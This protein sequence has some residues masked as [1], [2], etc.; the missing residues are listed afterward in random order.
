M[1]LFLLLLLFFS[2]LFLKMWKTGMQITFLQ[3]PTMKLHV[4]LLF[5]L[6][7]IYHF[8]SF[9][10]NHFCETHGGMSLTVNEIVIQLVV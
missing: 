10:K 5:L 4:S 9:V 1:K 7:V 8:V 6:G 2:T 3:S